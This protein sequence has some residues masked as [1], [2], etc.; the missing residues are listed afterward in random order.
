VGDQKSFTSEIKRDDSNNYIS[1]KK[2]SHPNNAP[3]C[4]LEIELED[5]SIR[6][7]SVSCKH[8][9]T[10]FLLGFNSR[11]KL[12]SLTLKCLL[13]SCFTLGIL[14]ELLTFILKSKKSLIILRVGG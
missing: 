1:V 2:Y 9:Q 7:H 3:A 5:I 8:P 4:F 13:I 6:L 14:H 12:I 10:K 11:K